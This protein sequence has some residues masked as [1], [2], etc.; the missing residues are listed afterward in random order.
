[1]SALRRALLFAIDVRAEYLFR[2]RWR[3]SDD[4]QLPAGTLVTL[5][6]DTGAL[7][8]DGDESQ[9]HWPM[10]HERFSFESDTCP[11]ADWAEVAPTTMAVA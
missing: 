6:D 4:T 3:R 11:E 2:G 1:M 10:S 9:A 8:V 7:H 5:N